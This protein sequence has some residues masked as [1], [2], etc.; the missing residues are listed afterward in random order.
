MTKN[1]KFQHLFSH[2][3]CDELKD[4][5]VKN[6]TEKIIT[7]NLEKNNN[8][9]VYKECLNCVDLTSLN[10]SDNETKIARMI[11]KV[12]DFENHF[13]NI[14]NVAAVCVYPSLV[15]I[16]K[17]TL[18]EPIAIASV[19]AGFPASQTFLEVKVAETSMS[20][21]EGAREIDVVISVGKFLEED[22]TAVYEELSE[23]KA[24]C[25][26]VHLKVI[27]EVG[28]LA[29]AKNIKK[30]SLLAMQ[31]GADFIKTSTGKIAVSATPEATFVMCSAIKE[32]YEQTGQK[33]GYKVAGGVSTTEEVVKHYT[34]VQQ[35]LGEEWLNNQLF[36]VGASRLANQLLTSI[37]G[38]EQNYF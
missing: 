2:Y 16:V 22:Y 5:Y 23:L 8:I 27:L 32:W 7:D 19:S 35:I 30:A 14:K 9:E 25:R 34:L 20:I 37:T 18:T 21:M 36:R 24:T 1:E 4:E 6:E 12:N 11:E 10:E 3:H 28:A 29:S 33:V 17:E 15:P 26:D 31:A 13:V 38:T